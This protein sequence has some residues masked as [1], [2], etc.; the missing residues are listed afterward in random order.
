MT[1]VECHSLSTAYCGTLT[2][3]RKP[4][5]LH[6]RITMAALPWVTCRNQPPGHAI[7]ISNI[8]HFEIGLDM[9]LSTSNEST[10]LSI[11]LITSP[12]ISL[13]FYFAGT[14]I[15]YL[16]ISLL[17]TCRY[18]NMQSQCMAMQKRIMISTFLIHLRPPL[19]LPQHGFMPRFKKTSKA[20]RSSGSCGMTSYNPTLHFGLWEGVLV[21]T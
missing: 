6:T 13:G 2:S 14:P 19:Q 20:I 5:L 21:Y 4:Q 1:L 18:I 17:N 11:S 16:D 8:L 9:I 3:P 10:S 7:L 12:N 15:T